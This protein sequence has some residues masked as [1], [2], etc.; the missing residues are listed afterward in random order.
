MAGNGDLVDRRVP[1]VI[2]AAV[3]GDGGGEAGEVE[4]ALVDLA[5]DLDH[6]G[7]EFGQGGEGKTLRGDHEKILQTSVR[8]V[9]R[10]FTKYV[11]ISPAFFEL[12]DPPGHPLHRPSP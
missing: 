7:L 6:L 2:P 12:P 1:A 5:L 10:K 3:F 8:Y 9:N 11:P 4:L